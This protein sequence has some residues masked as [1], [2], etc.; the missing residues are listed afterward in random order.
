VAVVAAVALPDGAG[1]VVPVPWPSAVAGNISIAA[2][3]RA[4]NTAPDLMPLRVERERLP[5][6]LF[7]N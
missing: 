5:S 2:S 7:T 4:S 1:V 6:L 3:P